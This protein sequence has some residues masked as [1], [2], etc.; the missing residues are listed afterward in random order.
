MGMC[1]CPWRPEEGTESLAIGVIGSCELSCV[2]TRNWIWVLRESI[3]S[4][5]C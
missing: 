5:N 4:L 3:K 1:M 2:D